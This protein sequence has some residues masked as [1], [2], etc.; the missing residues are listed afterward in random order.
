MER[1]FLLSV[2]ETFQSKESCKLGWI[3][4]PIMHS[5]ETSP[6]NEIELKSSNLWF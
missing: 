1:V 5:S 3:K 4:M 2:N 6:E